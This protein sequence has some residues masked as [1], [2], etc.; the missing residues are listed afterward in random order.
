MWTVLLLR[1]SENLNRE[2]LST[3]AVPVL[4]S[5]L[6][7]AFFVR[8]INFSMLF[9]VFTGSSFT[10]WPLRFNSTRP[11]TPIFL[12][13]QLTTLLSEITDRFLRSDSKWI[14]VI[15]DLPY[16]ILGANFLHHYALL[17]DGEMATLAKQ[18]LNKWCSVMSFTKV[19]LSLSLDYSAENEYHFILRYSE[20][21]LLI[22]H[23]LLHINM[24]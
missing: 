16:P 15:A 12:Y 11:Q 9:I 22:L 2:A 8:E 20:K 3:S 19:T 17:D 14:F 10:I 18:F 23:E 24:Q 1:S 7:C 6:Y 5:T 13:M 4:R 21:I